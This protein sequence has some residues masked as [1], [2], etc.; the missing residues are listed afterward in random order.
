MKIARIDSNQP[1][2]VK[3]F[4]EEGFSVHHTHM[5][6]GGFVDI[7]VGRSG[8]NYL[9]EIKDGEKSPSKRKLT[10]DEQEFHSEWKGTIFIVETVTDVKKL[11]SDLI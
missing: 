5:V 11:S 3:A 9:V 8:I 2:I 6:G 4:R 1:I 7:V 10:P